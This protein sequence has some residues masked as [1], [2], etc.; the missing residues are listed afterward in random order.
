MV[1]IDRFISSCTF[2]DGMDVSLRATS[3]YQMILVV[4]VVEIKC[5]QAQSFGLGGQQ[6]GKMD[7][8][9]VFI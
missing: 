2:I 5:Q 4:E 7:V 6:G 8:G 1:Q 3:D 9:G